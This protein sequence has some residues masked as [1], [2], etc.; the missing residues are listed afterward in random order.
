[1]SSNRH[2]L[3][4][5]TIYYQFLYGI[6]KNQ[7][8]RIEKYFC[9]FNTNSKQ[10]GSI[11]LLELTVYDCIKMTDDAILAREAHLIYQNAF[12]FEPKEGNMTNW[13]G[14]VRDSEGSEVELTMELPDNFPNVPPKFRLPLDYNHPIVGPDNNIN[15]RSISRWRK[16]YH[17]YQV[18]REVRQAIAS[19]KFDGISKHVPIASS[20][21]VLR[22]QLDYL[23][24]EL[25]NKEQEFERIKAAPP[26]IAQGTQ[27]ALA[28]EVNEDALVNI[29]NDLWS[30]EDEYD[31]LE[32]DGKT[33]TSKY[34]KL[35]KRYYMISKSK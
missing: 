5:I 15:T 33:F 28:A 35:Q 29:Q 10:I 7:Q 26:S 11:F 12:G 17:A 34:L 4:D 24:Q 13:K 6:I 19:A 30:L 14:I 8:L 18:I 1:M 9:L 23:K 16:D 21:D 22:R 31:H 20:D 3:L 2:Y 27:Q 32:I 25:I